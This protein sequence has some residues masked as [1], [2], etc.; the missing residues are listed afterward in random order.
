VIG[1]FAPLLASSTR[2]A[3]GTESTIASASSTSSAS[4]D[5]DEIQPG[6]PVGGR[7]FDVRATMAQHYRPTG[8]VAVQELAAAVVPDLAPSAAR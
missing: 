3:L 5:T 1:R 4:A 8:A 7:R 6:H 2:S